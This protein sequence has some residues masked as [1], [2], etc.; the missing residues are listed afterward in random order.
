MPF[1]IHISFNPVIKLLFA[2][3]VLYNLVFSLQL[4]RIIKE[5]GS[6]YSSRQPQEMNPELNKELYQFITLLSFNDEIF[7]KFLKV[8]QE[9]PED[10]YFQKIIF[11]RMYL[12]HSKKFYETLS[13]FGYINTSEP[14]YASTLDNFRF[15]IRKNFR[16]FTVP[17]LQHNYIK[18]EQKDYFSISIKRL[19]EP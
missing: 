14:S 9:L 1:K 4:V 5:S 11:D 13:F 18:E 6:L 15:S 7:Y 19:I 3:V 2:V 10:I 16:D 12:K 8:N 17:F